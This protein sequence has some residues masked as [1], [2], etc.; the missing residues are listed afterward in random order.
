MLKLLSKFMHVFTIKTQKQLDYEFLAA[1]SDS[2]E[3]EYRI[4]VLENR[5]SNNYYSHNR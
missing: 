2:I 3:L 1:S 5:P 4:K